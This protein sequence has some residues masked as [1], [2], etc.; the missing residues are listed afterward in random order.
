MPTSNL[1][2]TQEV[3]E[4]VWSI[5]HSDNDTRGKA[6]GLRRLGER[7]LDNDRYGDFSIVEEAFNN[8][9]LKTSFAE[10]KIIPHRSAFQLMYSNLFNS[11]TGKLHGLVVHTKYGD[12]YLDVGS[13]D[14]FAKAFLH[15]LR[16]NLE[17]GYYNKGD[18]QA[19]L[20]NPLLREAGR[21]AYTFLLP[22][23]NA[24]YGGCEFF[25]F[26]APE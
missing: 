12:Y 13:P 14:M 10:T 22:S 26:T 15:V 4:E 7:L 2:T 11:Q 17:W 8:V 6:V 20:D 18:A 21:A 19:I 16:K 23:Q 9:V 25:S 5:L 1:M 3:E 24:E